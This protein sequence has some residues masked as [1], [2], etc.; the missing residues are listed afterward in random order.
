MTFQRLVK[1]N[2]ES[3]VI[4]GV[5]KVPRWEHGIISNLQAID[6]CE[7]GP[8][9]HLYNDIDRVGMASLSI[10]LLSYNGSLTKTILLCDLNG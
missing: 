1:D 8:L 4:H 10:I 2:V 3:T 9:L 6:T 5:D 7:S